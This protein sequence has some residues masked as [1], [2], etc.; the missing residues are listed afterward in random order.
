[1]AFWKMRDTLLKFK[2][3]LVVPL[4]WET[5][6]WKSLWMRPTHL[7]LC[8]NV[9]FSVH[10]FIFDPNEKPDDVAAH[11]FSST[12][13]SKGLKHC[14]KSLIWFAQLAG[15][16]TKMVTVIWGLSSCS[17]GIMSLFSQ[18]RTACCRNTKGR[19][20]RTSEIAADLPGPSTCDL[21]NL[22][23]VDSLS[24]CV[25]VSIFSCGANRVL[26][27]TYLDKW[28][29]THVWGVHKWGYPQTIHFNGLFHYKSSIWGSLI[30]GNYI[31]H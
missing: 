13:S 31:N 4:S 23:R 18:T 8:E 15:E 21:W 12:S 30:N 17:W 28:Q 10:F 20:P 6:S 16:H 25:C 27:R 26:Q 11:I 7:H 19:T 2:D 14:C 22:P 1:M 9:R 29:Y 3:Q 24:V 5:P